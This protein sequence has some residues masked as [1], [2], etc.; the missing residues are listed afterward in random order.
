MTGVPIYP[1]NA[2]WPVPAVGIA[3]GEPLDS[4]HVNQGARSALSAA[5]ALRLAMLGDWQCHGYTNSGQ[6]DGTPR[7]MIYGGWDDS[8]KPLTYRRATWVA[9]QYRSST[10]EGAY[11]HSGAYEASGVLPA[12]TPPAS[13]I[14]GYAHCDGGIVV[15]DYTTNIA[16]FARPSSLSYALDAGTAIPNFPQASYFMPGTGRGDLLVVDNISDIHESSANLT[17]WTHTA[18]GGGGS[19]PVGVAK[20]NG[21]YALAS[22]TNRYVYH[23]TT[24]S[25]A[26]SLG[27]YHAA[28]SG[29]ASRGLTFDRFWGVFVLWGHHDS[30]T[31]GLYTS[32]DCVTWAAGGIAGLKVTQ[33]GTNQGGVWVAICET[34][35]SGIS[36]VL[37]SVDAGATWVFVAELEDTFLNGNAC[38]EIAWGDRRFAAMGKNRVWFSG[39][40]A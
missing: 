40:L 12:F 29:L 30:D 37:A 25:Q 18:T 4:A 27:T 35:Y 17:T 14:R 22:A 19:S 2:N 9:M 39:R 28:S 21:V 36:R 33:F 8:T 15:L 6:A 26:A 13:T 7:R 10:L 16:I 24:A 20:G 34:G 23:G 1:Y 38:N 11:S 5:S 32:A 3:D 31:Q